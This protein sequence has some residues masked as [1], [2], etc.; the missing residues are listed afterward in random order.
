MQRAKSGFNWE[1]VNRTLDGRLI[2]VDLNWSAV[3]GHEK[4]L[5]R[6]IVAAID[7]TERKQAEKLQDAIYRIAQAADQ[8]ES[9]DALYPAIHTIIRETMVAD[10]FYIALY[11]E[12]NDM[13]SFPYFVDAMEPS[14]PATKPGKGLDRVCPA[15][16]ASRCC[17]MRRCLSS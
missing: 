10:N 9:L 2:D 12:E 11:D 8:T 17:V 6:V 16:A 1:G 5:S 14:A 13:L 15:H 3:P 4:T 7:I